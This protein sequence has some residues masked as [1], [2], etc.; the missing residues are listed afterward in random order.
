MVCST[1]TCIVQWCS[2]CEVVYRKTGISN[3]MLQPGVQYGSPTFT[4]HPIYVLIKS[5]C[6][7][8]WFK[9]FC[10]SQTPPTAFSF[11]GGSIVPKQCVS[12]RNKQFHRLI[13]NITLPMFF[14]KSWALLLLIGLP[15]CKSTKQRYMWVITFGWNCVNL[16]INGCHGFLTVIDK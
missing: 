9:H 7:D 11:E 5:F 15:I 8:Q 16:L 10:C 1:S 13:V 3:K 4:S 2:D 12:A 14:R 6:D